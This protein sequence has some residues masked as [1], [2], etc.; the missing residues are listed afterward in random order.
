MTSKT[1]VPW[2]MGNVDDPNTISQLLV[3]EVLE[4]S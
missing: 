1:V 2:G 3:R 4:K